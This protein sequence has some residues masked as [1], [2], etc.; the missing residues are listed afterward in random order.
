MQPTFR[1][2]LTTLPLELAL[3]LTMVC[4]YVRPKSLAALCDF[5]G[6]CVGQNYARATL[7]VGYLRIL[8]PLDIISLQLLS[9]CLLV[10][11]LTMHVRD[12]DP[13]P[14]PLL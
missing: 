4:A 11:Q 2:A 6:L 13:D 7:Q 3:D 14:V 10:V 8:R 9:A 12:V 1:H 5:H